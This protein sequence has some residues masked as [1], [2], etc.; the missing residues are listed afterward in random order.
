MG[1]N[2]KI[3]TIFIVVILAIGLF[4]LFKGCLCNNMKTT[5][6]FDCPVMSRISG[7]QGKGG[8]CSPSY[9]GTNG[10]CDDGCICNN[11][12]CENPPPPPPPP[13][14][15]CFIKETLVT[16]ADGST[17]CINTI[18][19]G[20]L[21]KSGKTGLP[22]VVLFTNIYYGDHEIFGVNNM[23]PFATTNHHFLGVNDKLM[24]I[25]M[26]DTYKKR[27]PSNYFEQL[28]NGSKLKTID[29]NN[30]MVETEVKNINIENITNTNVYDLMTSDHSFIANNYCVSDNFPN[31]EGNKKVALRI[32]NIIDL[33]HKNNNINETEDTIYNKYYN[34][35]MNIP[36]N[37]ND[38]NDKFKEFILLCNINV[39][40]IHLAHDLFNNKF[41]ELNKDTYLISNNI[42]ETILNE[43]VIV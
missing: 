28:T 36:I 16:M 38:F 12:R 32:S 26:D 33:V 27:W 3:D 7:R 13:K 20:E 31:I 14:N 42:E 24:A 9:I 8:S 10:G 4:Y 41:D 30:N 5:E 11:Q 21:V 35:I 29:D 15:P 25:N 34:I 17:K 18:K 40:Y 6:N 23:K 43:T 2:F 22:T 1:G 19:S 37:E 39:K